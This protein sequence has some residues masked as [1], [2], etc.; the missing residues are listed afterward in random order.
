LIVEVYL[1]PGKSVKKRPKIK[2]RRA[3]NEKLNVQNAGYWED[4]HPRNEVVDELKNDSLAQWKTDSGYHDCSISETAMS[5]YKGLTS[6]TLSLICY[7]AQVGEALANVKAMNKV[8]GL[9][10]PIRN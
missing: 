10:M 7:N 5:R 9:G 6:G 8:L 3:M 2:N 4:G 1:K